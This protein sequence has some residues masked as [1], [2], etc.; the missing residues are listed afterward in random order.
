MDGKN[1]HL[2]RELRIPVYQKQDF[3]FRNY[4]QRILTKQYKLNL[5]L[6]TV[7]FFKYKIQTAKAG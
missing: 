5:L 2:K 7:F 6:F 1:N 4:I 3:E